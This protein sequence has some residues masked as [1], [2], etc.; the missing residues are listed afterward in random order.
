[1]RIDPHVGPVAFDGVLQE[2]LHAL[3]DLFAQARYLALGG[4][5]HAQSL[6]QLVDRTRRNS[7]NVGFLNDRRERRLGRAPRF[8]KVGKVAAGAQAWKSS[9]RPCRHAFRGIARG[10]RCGCWRV[11]RSARRLPL[12]KAFRRPFPS[13]VARQ[14]KPVK[15]ISDSAIADCQG[16]KDS[17]LGMPESNSGALP[18]WRSPYSSSS[19]NEVSEF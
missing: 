7:L 8:Q 19:S 13:A 17:N 3:V 10:S 6:D 11:H 9:A 14:G 5:A 15:A 16:D 1:M 18:A 4:A 2:S 12:D